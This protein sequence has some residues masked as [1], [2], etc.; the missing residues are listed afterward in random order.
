[1][2]YH[3]QY[4]PQ[5][6]HKYP[7]VKK[8]RTVRNACIAL[9]C[10]MLLFSVALTRDK[11]RSWLFPGDPAVTDA[12]IDQMVETLRAGD[13]LQEAISVFCMEVLENGI[14]D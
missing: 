9:A 7:V 12:A 14:Q 10:C 6:N 11:L 1:M 2:G 5:M 3:I 4:S 8:K 13:G